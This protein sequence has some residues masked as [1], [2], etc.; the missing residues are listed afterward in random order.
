[1]IDKGGGRVQNQACL[2]PVSCRFFSELPS[3]FAQFAAVTKTRLERETLRGP[4]LGQIKLHLVAG[5]LANFL[6]T[7]DSQR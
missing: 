6:F 7:K 1:M 5:C 3:Q 4:I 2:K